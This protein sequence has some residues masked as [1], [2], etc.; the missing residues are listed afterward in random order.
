MGLSVRRQRPRRTETNLDT[1]R[2]D[3]SHVELSLK[4]KCAYLTLENCMTEENKAFFHCLPNLWVEYWVRWSKDLP[5]SMPLTKPPF[6]MGIVTD[7]FSRRVTA[8]SSRCIKPS[9][10]TDLE[11]QSRNGFLSCT[12]ICLVLEWGLVLL[13]S[14]LF[15]F[16]GPKRKKCQSESWVTESLL[17]FPTLLLTVFTKLAYVI[18]EWN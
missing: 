8:R 2:N 9:M 7:I 17:N 16:I 10:V 1:R 15:Y 4:C 18:T 11:T 13:Y 14:L 5:P 6:S 12:V 3:C